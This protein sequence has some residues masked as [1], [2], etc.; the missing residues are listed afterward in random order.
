[1]TRVL[2]LLVSL[3]IVF[4]LVVLVGVILPSHGHIERTVEV[5]SPLR[6]IFDSVDTFRRFPEWAAQ[7]RI[8]PQTKF[9]F[10]GPE[11]G[12]NAKVAWESTAPQLGNGSL[13]IT[14]TEQDSKVTMS[15]D[16][17]WSGENKTYTITLLPAQN[18]KTVNINWA[19]D[20]DY[21][22]NLIWRYAGL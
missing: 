21:G 8:D 19:Y 16:N 15:L 2:E 22:W 6:Q 17:P 4:V 1:M 3:V 11:S 12:Q 7:R 18:G 14:G 5:S 13:T 10:A 9:T 20:A